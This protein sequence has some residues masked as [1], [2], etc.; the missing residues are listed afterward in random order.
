MNPAA[1]LAALALA[2][3]PTPVEHAPCPDAA[4]ADD[5]GCYIPAP[6]DRIY[7]KPD[8]PATMDFITWHERGHAADSHYFTAGERHR[9]TCLAA[10]RTDA[11][12]S[13]CGKPWGPAMRERLADAYASC[14]FRELPSRGRDAW[15]VLYDYRPATDRQQVNAC[16]FIAR[17]AS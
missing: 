9:F 15:T 2:V 12:R 11:G 3:A 1:V 13:R 14:H 5:A 6:V 10:V 17:A 8:D 7:V 16:R 4:H